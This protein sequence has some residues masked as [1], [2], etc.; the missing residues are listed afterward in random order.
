MVP[1]LHVSPTFSMNPIP[2]LGVHIS[3]LSR[4]QPT[5]LKASAE[6]NFLNANLIT[7]PALWNYCQEENKDQFE[8]RNNKKVGKRHEQVFLRKGT[9]N[10][11]NTFVIRRIHVKTTWIHLSGWQTHTHTSGGELYRGA[12][13]TDTL[14]RG[15]RSGSWKDPGELGL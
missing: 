10:I 5:L 11:S 8:M 15:C 1:A 13:G 6:D 12:Q 3:S 2:L 9:A 4:L 14:T 7:P